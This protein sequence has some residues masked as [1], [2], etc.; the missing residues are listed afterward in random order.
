M[1][2]DQ[3]PLILGIMSGTSCDGIDVAIMRMSPV[4]GLRPELM[5]FQSLP[6]PDE[7]REPILRL[8]EPGIHE[9]D[10]MGALH[11]QLGRAYGKAA[12]RAIAAAGLE[13]DD[14][15]AIGCHGQTL[16]HR[17]HG[18]H[19]FTLQIGC[20]ATIAEQTGITTISNFRSRD[21][22]AGGEGAPLVP[23]AHQQ[24]FASDDA[25]IAMLNIGGIANLTWLGR[26]GSITGFDCGPGNMLMDG[27][28]LALS[29]GRNSYDEDG[30]LAASGR[31]CKPLLEELLNIPFLHKSPPKSTGREEFGS[32]VIDSILAW[33]EISDADRL[34]TACALSVEVIA[35]SVRF[36][37]NPPGRWLVC[38]GGARNTHLM[39]CLASRLAPASLDGTEA[40]GIPG[41]AVEAACFAMLARETLCGAVNTVAEVTGA[42]HAVCGGS[43]TPGK[44]WTALL[45]DIP[46]WTR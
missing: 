24:L 25:D 33:P 2:S 44:N 28:I 7:L 45:R 40:C 6:M 5:H 30:G 9:I 41:Q 17:P 20:A 46:T 27:L 36:L 29:D 1:K 15:T 22:A 32:E 14:I 21:I 39:R 10:A 18:K 23:F 11:V 38:G 3:H 12:L 31:I 26:D 16:R 37:P 43:I 13:T 19:P 4:I 8:A 34:A 42:T 35:G